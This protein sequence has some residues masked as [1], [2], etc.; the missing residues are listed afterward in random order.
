MIT[1]P[2][3][4]IQKSKGRSG[5]YYGGGIGF[6]H[7]GVAGSFGISWLNKRNMMYGIEYLHT[8]SKGYFLFDVKLKL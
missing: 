8:E 4:V 3:P 5:L 7:E 1:E 2:Y 6:A